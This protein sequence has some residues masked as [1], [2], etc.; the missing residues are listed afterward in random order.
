MKQKIALVIGFA[1]SMY[2][3]ASTDKQYFDLLVDVFIMTLLALLLENVIRLKDKTYASLI[4]VIMA[5]VFYAMIK[6]VKKTGT[7]Y[8]WT[9]YVMWILVPLAIIIIL[10]ADLVKT[11]KNDAK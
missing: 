4:V 6:Q 9:D 8:V 5:T 2:A 7:I 1:F 11:F 10:I 3:Y